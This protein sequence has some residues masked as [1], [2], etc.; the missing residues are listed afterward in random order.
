MKNIFKIEGRIQPVLLVP[1]IITILTFVIQTLVA[2]MLILGLPKWIR[3]WLETFSTELPAVIIGTVLINAVTVTGY[4][5]LSFFYKNQWRKVLI[6][7]T[8]PFIN[9]PITAGYIFLIIFIH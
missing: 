5:L 8:I 1:A 6:L 4:I 3:D 2:I 9:I 7:S